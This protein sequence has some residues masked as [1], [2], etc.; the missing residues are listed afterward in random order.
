MRIAKK[1]LPAVPL[2]EMKPFHWY[3]TTVLQKGIW[4]MFR[5]HCRRLGIDFPCIHERKQDV[6]L[7][8][9]RACHCE[10]IFSPWHLFCFCAPGRRDATCISCSSTTFQAGNLSNQG[11][12]LGETHRCLRF[13]PARFQWSP[14]TD[15]PVACTEAT[16]SRKV[17]INLSLH[18]T[19]LLKQP[20]L[21]SS[22]Y[23]IHFLPSFLAAVLG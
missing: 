17:L 4:F 10:I 8:Q 15:G 2:L 18:H 5:S 11:S 13:S 16:K 9:C 22:T 7:S 1:V 6:C 23:W 14:R 20:L 19:R 3:K 12:D 21:M